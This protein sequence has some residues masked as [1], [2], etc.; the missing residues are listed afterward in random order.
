[1][2]IPGGKRHVEGI[3]DGNTTIDQPNLGKIGG[4]DV[5]NVKADDLKFENTII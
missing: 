4:D 2:A 3:G 5:L 1:M